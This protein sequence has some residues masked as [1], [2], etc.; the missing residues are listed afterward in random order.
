MVLII[1]GILPK[2]PLIVENFQSNSKQLSFRWLP[3]GLDQVFLL[4]LLLLRHRSLDGG[5][6]PSNGELSALIDR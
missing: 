2:K 5:V 4:P 6:L 1:W 3:I